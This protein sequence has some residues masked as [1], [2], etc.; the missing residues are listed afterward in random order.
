MLLKTTRSDPAAAAGALHLRRRAAARMLVLDPGGKLLLFRFMHVRGA[1]AGQDFWA[2]PGGGV[3]VGETHTE[4]A[5]RELRQETGIHAER[6]DA[7]VAHCETVLQL[8]DGES[9]IADEHYFVVRAQDRALTRDQWS[10]REAEVMVAQ[11]WWTAAELESTTDTVWPANLPA[12][13]RNAG[14]W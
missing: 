3:E 10:V 9:V 1:L 2:T 7:P 6:L 13:L 5:I 12:M 11:H 4:A 8:P 14:C